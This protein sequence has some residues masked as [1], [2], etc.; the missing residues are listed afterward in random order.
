M[1]AQE[2]GCLSN[3]LQAARFQPH[4]IISSQIFRVKSFPDMAQNESRKRLRE[5][6]STN[7]DLHS[8][9]APKMNVCADEGA[10]DGR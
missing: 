9:R 8:K 1:G 4:F 5:Q 7:R 3:S 2:I 10:G 6:E